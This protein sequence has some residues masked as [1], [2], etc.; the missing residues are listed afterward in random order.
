MSALYVSLRRVQVTT[1]PFYGHLVIERGETI[2]VDSRVNGDGKR[3]FWIQY[4]SGDGLD[5]RIPAC[6]VP[7]SEVSAFDRVD[8]G[9]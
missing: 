2:L 7:L 9:L 1:L 6:L 8:L 4:P 3:E 5:I